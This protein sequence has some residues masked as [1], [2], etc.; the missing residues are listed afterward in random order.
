MLRVADLHTRFSRSAFLNFLHL[1]NQ[2]F[3]TSRYRLT[4]MKQL[5]NS[6]M[7]DVDWQIRAFRNA[8]SKSMIME[9]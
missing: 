1:K 5:C 4:P 3:G 9:I 8:L 7:Q 6:E 2:R